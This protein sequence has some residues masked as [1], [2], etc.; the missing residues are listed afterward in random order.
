MP[1]DDN[2]WANYKNP[3]HNL[4]PPQTT[5]RHNGGSSVIL[6]RAIILVLA[7][8]VSIALSIT[9]AAI[10]D[11][12][13]VDIVDNTSEKIA[14]NN[15]AASIAT[16]PPE[17]QDSQLDN[18]D[19][20]EPAVLIEEEPVL[21][22]EPAEEPE[23]TPIDENPILPEI[24]IEEEI[25]PIEEPENPVEEP[26]V[27][28]PEEDSVD[29]S[30]PLIP[31]E[32]KDLANRLGLTAEAKREFY[33]HEPSIFEDA[34]APGYDCGTSDSSTV[35]IYG[36]WQIDR[37][38][39]LRTSTMETTAAHELLHAIYYE[40]YLHNET[41]VLD[42]HL[43]KFKE[44]HPDKVQEI[45]ERYANHYDYGDET[46]RQWAE[47][48]E[49]HSFIGTQFPEIP[50]ELEDHYAKYFKNRRK[51][52]NFYLNWEKS[53]E[54]KNQENQSL[55]AIADKQREEYKKCLSDWNNTLEYC[56]TFDSDIDAYN[57]YSQCL[58]SDKTLFSDCLYLKPE[59]IPYTAPS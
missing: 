41:D 24:G 46:S 16:E 47:Y 21:V 13:T 29:Q 39:I 30:Y 56:R 40:L 17:K 19:P 4:N 44:D 38:Y 49:L 26:V 8:L 2:N 53:F 45:L 58:A 34:D 51:V 36:C 14:N 6:P 10:F 33:N 35:I 50:Q 25:E 28:P 32:V 9:A 22:E 18:N 52:A 23:S 7:S 5:V 37:I 55:Q 43:A 12:Q 57:T 54:R 48:N 42:Q 11:D 27:E 20:E 3:G 59:F 15:P 1:P 31:R